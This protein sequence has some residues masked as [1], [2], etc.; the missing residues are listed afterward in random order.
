MIQY[1]KI[2]IVTFFLCTI[3]FSAHTKVI[4]V[5]DADGLNYRGWGI[6]NNKRA[7]DPEKNNYEKEPEGMDCVQKTFANGAKCYTD[8]K[9]STSVYKYSSETC[10]GPNFSAPTD[11]GSICTDD[12]GT[13]YKECACS[14]NLLTVLHNDYSTY[15]DISSGV[16]TIKSE[17]GFTLLSCYDPTKFTCKDAYLQLTN[18]DIESGTEVSYTKAVITPNNKEPLKYT[19]AT[20]MPYSDSSNS[21]FRACVIGEDSLCPENSTFNTTTETCE[22]MPTY[23]MV[24]QVCVDGVTYCATLSK[25]FKDG[26]CETCVS[27]TSFDQTAKMCESVCAS[28][29]TWNGT[30]CVCAPDQTWN[31]TECVCA[32]DQTWNGTECVCAEGYHKNSSGKCT[33]DECLICP[34]NS[35]YNAV[36]KRCLCDAGMFYKTV[37]YYN[38]DKYGESRCLKEISD[39]FFDDSSKNEKFI[40]MGHT[41][42]GKMRVVELLPA[43]ASISAGACE[44]VAGGGRIIDFLRECIEGDRLNNQLS[45]DDYKFIHEK[46]GSAMDDLQKSSIY[47]DCYITKDGMYHVKTK[48]IILP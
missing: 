33:I 3:S 30:E 7:C 29:Q 15:F 10:K 19:V 34:E 41:S 45:Y 2:I 1:I 31:G 39:D 43:I 17:T 5:D 25:E 9:C 48:S 36:S 22:C 18:K 40:V 4:K 35:T 42:D 47:A 6:V 44:P 23:M 24:D 32:S 28:N 46:L 21:A 12:E 26:K 16:Y 11:E 14:K 13:Y 20:N 27:G 8:C 37:P 38:K